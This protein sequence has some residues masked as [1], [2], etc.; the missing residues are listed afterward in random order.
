MNTCISY[1]ESYLHGNF[2]GKQLNATKPHI[3]DKFAPLQVCALTCSEAHYTEHVLHT[4]LQN[5]VSQP[6]HQKHHHFNSSVCKL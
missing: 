5:W 3:S 1:T 2:G 6:W 4:C